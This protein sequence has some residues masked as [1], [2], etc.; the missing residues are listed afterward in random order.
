MKPILFPLNE[1]TFES[2]GIG[3]LY[4]AEECVVTEEKNGQYELEMKYPI[5]GIHYSE[6]KDQC[7]ILAKTSPAHKLRSEWQ[8]FRVYRITKPLK[9]FVK[10]YAQ[11][12]SYDLSGIPV[13]PFTA[14][15][16]ATALEGL[17]M[18]STSHFTVQTDKDLS[19]TFTNSVPTSFRSLLG[20]Q[21]G[22]ILDLY[23]GEFEFDRYTVKLWAHRGSTTKR[24]KVRYGKNLTDLEQDENASNVLTGVLCYWKGTASSIAAYDSTKTYNIGDY[25]KYADYNYVCTV[26]GTTGEWNDDNWSV[27]IGEDI[28]VIGDTKRT[29]INCYDPEEV[30][31]VGDISMHN[32]SIYE[33]LADGTTGDWD[34]TKWGLYFTKVTSV[35]ASGD[36]QEVPLKSELNDYTEIYITK[37]DLDTPTVSLKISFV[38]LAGSP[39]YENYKFLESIELCD[40][41]DVEYERLKV[42]TTAKVIKT[43]FNVLKDRYDSVE[44][45]SSRSNIAQTIAEQQERSKNLDKKFSSFG[46][47]IQAAAEYAAAVITGAR[48]GYVIL[49]DTYP[50]D[51][52]PD[53]LF[54]LDADSGGVI[55]NSQHQWR[56]NYAGMGYSSNYGV[57]WEFA[58][59]M[60]GEVNANFI[61]TGEL[62]GSLIRTGSIMVGAL[63]GGYVNDVY[64]GI[65]DA[66]EG[67]EIY[68]DAQLLEYRN[69]IAQYL[70]FD[71]ATGLTIGA[72]N[73]A[74]K[75]I[76]SN[77]KLSFMDGVTEVAYISNER[78]FIEDGIIRNSLRIGNYVFE[79]RTNGN[80]SLVFKEEFE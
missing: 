74:F 31:N 56:W 27:F 28:T 75:A 78:F 39:E 64:S 52:K 11:H 30:Y 77:T 41:V 79:P 66:K 68:S 2:N 62:N 19:T 76:L 71:A 17:V 5:T 15:S 22:S 49:K 9:G 53:T 4:D 18:H 3:T 43:V 54:I 42:N 45:G 60:G 6:I 67:A 20:G 65:S 32:G 35:D 69:E 58:V 55:A 40:T 14:G 57:D 46:P 44:L 13:M 33:C 21:T 80:M 51:G 29:F 72:L 25:S 47:Q 36:F 70:T 63:D 34:S 8:P 7:L 1:L 12:I 48:G 38:E 24:P 16:A 37:R 10:I 23:G 26:D 59:T 61:T 50:Y 73:S